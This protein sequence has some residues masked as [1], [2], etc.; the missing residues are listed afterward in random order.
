[1]FPDQRGTGRSGALRCPALEGGDAEAR[2]EEATAV[3]RCGEQLGERRRF[4]TT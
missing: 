1:M 4:F 2:P 3:R